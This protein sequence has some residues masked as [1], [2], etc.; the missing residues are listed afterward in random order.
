WLIALVLYVEIRRVGN[1]N[2]EREDQV[3]A[4]LFDDVEIIEPLEE[5]LEYGL[6]KIQR[7][8]VGFGVGRVV[9]DD[10]GDANV[11]H[12]AFSHQVRTQ[13]VTVLISIS[14]KASESS[15]SPIVHA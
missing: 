7:G 10:H 9:V 1:G 15:P 14:A 13:R 8:I 4:G 11:G 12:Q 2:I 3:L 5:V 6:I